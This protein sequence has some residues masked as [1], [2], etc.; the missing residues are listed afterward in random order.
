MLSDEWNENKT[1]QNLWD[2]AKLLPR[3]KLT[4]VNVLISKEN[5]SQVRNLTFHLKKLEKEK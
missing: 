3:K 5:K 4:A 1:Y 2:A